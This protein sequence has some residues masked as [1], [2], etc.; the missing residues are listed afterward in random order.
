LKKTVSDAGKLIGQVLGGLLAPIRVLFLLPGAIKGFFN[1][2]IDEVAAFAKKL[3]KFNP[4]SAWM[5]TLNDISNFFGGG[6]IFGVKELSFSPFKNFFD[7]IIRNKLDRD[8]E[9]VLLPAPRFVPKPI[10]PPVPLP[11][12][13][14]PF[15]PLGPRVE[16]RGPIPVKQTEVSEV[17][18][19][20]EPERIIPLLPTSV[21]ATNVQK[22]ANKEL[23]DLFG[24]IFSGLTPAGAGTAQIGIT[25]NVD[26][27]ILA[28][29]VEN[30]SLT[31]EI[32]TRAGNR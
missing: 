22:E 2:I 1:E 11:G 14:T 6:D 26:G 30:V 23:F 21:E 16:D 28:E 20:E 4:F 7:D 25:L 29:A 8:P 19:I 9:S 3:G 31:R 32:N 10:R 18:P 12:L 27:E 15:A 5:D 13:G 17:R 24:G